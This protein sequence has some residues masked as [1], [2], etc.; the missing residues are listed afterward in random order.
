MFLF[1]EIAK[2]AELLHS[3]DISELMAEPPVAGAAR[4]RREAAA[5]AGVARLVPSPEGGEVTAHAPG[6]E[7]AAKAAVSASRRPP[8]GRE[9]AAA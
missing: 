9:R 1:G 5:S 8:R 7:V 3:S 6:T 2:T 4:K